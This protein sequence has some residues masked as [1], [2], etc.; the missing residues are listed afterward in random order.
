MNILFIHEVDWINKVVFDIHSLSESLSLLGHQVYAIDYENTWTKN[1]FWDL[2]SLKTKEVSDVS[3]AFPG[4]SVCLRRPG[5]IKIPGL[6]RLSAGFTHYLEISKTI[7][8]KKIDAI[9]LYSVA[10]NALQ[11]LYLAGKFKFPVLYRSIDIANQL[12]PYRALRPA[13]KL[14]EKKIYSGADM[15]LT[16]TP[17][18]SKYVVD[19]GAE[20]A[21]VKSLPMPVDTSLFHPSIDSSEVRK[22][23]GFDVND[24]IIVFIGTLFEFSGLDAFIP[25]FPEVV[26]QVPDAK[27]LIVGDGPQRPELEEII[28]DLNLQ[29]QVVITGFE[30]YR[31]MPQYIN[32]AAVCINTFRITG[33]TRDIF[34]GKIVQYLACGRAVIATWLPGMIAVISGENEGVLYTNSADGMVEN[35]ISLLKSPEGRQRLE[36]AGLSYVKQVHSHDI[37][38]RQLEAH[39]REAIKAK[40]R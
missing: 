33:A 31:T 3:R 16:L 25:R 37:I 34:P 17:K 13:V 30:P 8:E 35:I 38:A 40:V 7:R 32:L 9:I 23:W 4:A 1:G 20:E 15:I 27:L 39:I 19:L 10:T 12:V 5:F 14:M 2:G 29:K 36:Q 11:T 18:L 28:T 22:K 24:R 21:R 26:K 6:S